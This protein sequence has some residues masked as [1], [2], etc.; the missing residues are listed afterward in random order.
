MLLLYPVWWALGLGVLIYPILAVPMGIALLRRRRGISVPPGFWLWG[1]FLLVVVVSLAALEYDPPGTVAGTALSRMPGVALRLVEYASLTVLLLYAGNLTESELPRRRLIRLLG[2][3]FLIT[4][5]GGVVG[6]LW[7][8]LEFTS[9]VELLLPDRY[10]KNTFIRSLTHPAVAQLHQVLGFPTPRPAAPWGYTNIW[11]NNF[12][13]LLPW[14]VLAGFHGTRRW[15]KIAAGTV[16]A[17]SVIPVV[18]SLNRGLW[19]G[20]AVAAGYVAVRLALRGRLLAIGALALAGA[21]LTLLLATTPLGELVS[22]RMENGHSNDIRIY[23]TE[24]A[25]DGIGYSPVI[26]FGSTRNTLGSDS[27]IAVG[28]SAG[29]DNCG[30]HT[31][32]SNG[33]IWLELYAHGFLGAG[34]F[35]GFFGYA[36]WHY[37]RDHSAVGLAGSTVLVLNLL[38]SGY[39]NTLITPLAFTMLS[40]AVLWRQE[41]AP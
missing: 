22:S 33:Q 35:L 13:L 21:A 31:I 16:L 28:N 12:F 8:Q 23:T 32:G 6:T 14:F 18:I 27:S 41:T 40:L 36:L 20:L 2:W 19:L 38:G 4:V 24:Q 30:N 7:P 25:L 10:A 3:S 15:Q 17:V 1:L 34:L 9:P 5:V 11:G 37:R 26:G 39:Y 29:C